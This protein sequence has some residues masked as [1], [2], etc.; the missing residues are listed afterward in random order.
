MRLYRRHIRL[1]T[2]LVW[3]GTLRNPSEPKTLSKGKVVKKEPA[4]SDF[5]ID[6]LWD[7]GTP[8]ERTDRML[9]SHLR[10]SLERPNSTANGTPLGIWIK[11]TRF[12][13]LDQK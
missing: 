13:P 3:R 2:P 6:I 10:D 4:G 8:L 11:G 5:Y 12:D 7:A 1:G 9:L